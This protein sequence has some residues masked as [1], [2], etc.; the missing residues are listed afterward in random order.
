MNTQIQPL[1]SAVESRFNQLKWIGIVACVLEA[2]ILIVLV[3]K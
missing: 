1:V 2:L 3:V